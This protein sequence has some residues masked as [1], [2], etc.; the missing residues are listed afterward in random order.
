MIVTTIIDRRERRQDVTTYDSVIDINL[1]WLVR[2]INCRDVEQQNAPQCDAW[3]QPQN[4]CNFVTVQ[5]LHDWIPIQD[6][7]W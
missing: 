1:A 6:Y 7:K 5:T 4:L 3:Q 2:C